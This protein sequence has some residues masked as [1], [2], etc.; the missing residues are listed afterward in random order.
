MSFG[1]EF[2]IDADDYEAEEQAPQGP[3][4]DA[5]PRVTSSTAPKPAYKAK[6]GAPS[7]KFD[8]LFALTD[9]LRQSDRQQWIKRYAHLEVEDGPVPEPVPDDVDKDDDDGHLD[10]PN[11][12]GDVNVEAPSEEDGDERMPPVD[13]DAPSAQDAKPDASVEA[14]LPVAPPVAEDP[15]RPIGQDGADG[16]EAPSRQHHD[17]LAIA[18]LLLSVL[19]VLVALVPVMGK[20]LWIVP[21]IPSVALALTSVIVHHEE[22]PSIRVQV[23]TLM[24]AISSVALSLG[25]DA[26]YRN[27][28][29]IDTH[30]DDG[31]ALVRSQ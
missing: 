26:V 18:G 31:S 22:E 25:T 15:G 17:S 7:H 8:K 21:A 9:A 12:T 28:G 6:A 16:T 11:A 4:D 27:V 13:A 20:V 3:S 5:S 1:I 24:L 19:A 14:P 10:A 2:D 30:S 29:V 23:I